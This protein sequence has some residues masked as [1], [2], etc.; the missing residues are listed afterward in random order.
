[1][2]YLRD[3]LSGAYDVPKPSG[4]RGIEI[5]LEKGVTLICAREDDEWEIS[6]DEWS[7]GA[8]WHAGSSGRGWIGDS[9]DGERYRAP[10]LADVAVEL[11]LH[12]RRE[13]ARL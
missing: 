13:D 11:Y 6:W 4:R 2:N 7:L 3:Y 5:D 12:A 10:T 8:A 1:M 9:P